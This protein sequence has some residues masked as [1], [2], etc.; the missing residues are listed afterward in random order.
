MKIGQISSS[1]KPINGGQEVYIKNLNQ[2]LKSAGHDVTVYQ[3]YRGVKDSDIK[4]LPR[5]RGLG[6]L[7]KNG[8]LYLF[9]LMLLLIRNRYL[10]K[11]DVLIVHYAFHSLPVWDLNHRTI[12]LSH[13]IEWNPH[14]N[15]LADKLREKVARNS[16]DRFP[17]IA[18]DTHYFRHLGLEIAPGTNYFQQ[19]AHRKWFIP[20]CVDT[21]FFK[22]NNGIKELKQ[23]KVILVPRQV[24]PERGI[25]LAI[26]AFNIFN[27][28]DDRYILY[29]VGNI[30]KGQLKYY[31]ECQE[32][33][34]RLGLAQKV[35]FS[36]KVDNSLMPSYYSS[37]QLS[38][39]P[40]IRREGTS[41]SALESMA[42]GTATVTTNVE[43][44]K[45]LPAVKA[46]PNPEDL[47]DAMI[48]T[49]K[50]KDDFAEEQRRVTIKYFNISNWAD[51]WLNVINQVVK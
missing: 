50:R 46:N 39:I 19:I 14:S 45:D 41:L 49:I 1:Y 36:G 22:K 15:D 20:N 42:C 48:A 18:N 38:L 3:P 21:T 11:E 10:S 31:S 6:H 25:H 9:N 24:N 12:V 35:F 34:T 8:D 26:E 47:A 28:W 27:K 13:G 4:T 51:A 30:P 37:A 17:L 29:I 2:I 7:I 16:F 43:G 40:T 44:L 33:A 5:I 32:L 23:Q